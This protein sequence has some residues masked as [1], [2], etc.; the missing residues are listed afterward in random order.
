MLG[1]AGIL[2]EQIAGDVRTFAAVG[3]AL[4]LAAKGDGTFSVEGIAIG[5]NTA[6]TIVWSFITASLAAQTASGIDHT[7][8]SPANDRSTG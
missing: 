1:I 5:L 8:V 4:A 3:E 7:L 2:R 6:A